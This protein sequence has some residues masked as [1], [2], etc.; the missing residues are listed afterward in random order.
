MK[1]SPIQQTQSELL[2][3][4]I[5]EFHHWPQ[6]LPEMLQTWT[7]GFQPGKRR[8]RDVARC[9][10]HLAEIGRIRFEVM[11]KGPNRSRE[12]GFVLAEGGQTD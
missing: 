1:L 5:R 10:N 8:S 9:L 6:S 4:Y 11:D 3:S 7:F 2:W 12:I